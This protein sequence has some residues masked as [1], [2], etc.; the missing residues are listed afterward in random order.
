MDGFAGLNLFA[1]NLQL[2][3]W[4]VLL[5][6]LVLLVLLVLCSHFSNLA[7]IDDQVN[8]TPFFLLDGFRFHGPECLIAGTTLSLSIRMAHSHHPH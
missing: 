8:D 4:L 3:V 1:F 2:L 7:R 5:V 6:S